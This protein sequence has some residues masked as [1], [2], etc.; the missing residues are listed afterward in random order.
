MQAGN[1]KMWI[2]VESGTFAFL[3]LNICLNYIWVINIHFFVF[4][5][6]FFFVC[7][8]AF[9]PVNGAQG[10]T[11]CL[12][13]FNASKYCSQSHVSMS[14][15]T[16][17]EKRN[18]VGRTGKERKISCLKTKMGTY[19]AFPDRLVQYDEAGVFSITFRIIAWEVT[20]RSTFYFIMVHK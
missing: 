8:F 16:Y 10:K 6:V 2:G 17:K 20:R 3:Y 12:S 14:W 13:F 1:K 18:L 9:S 7:F 15:K 19:S 4:S 11:I 5:F